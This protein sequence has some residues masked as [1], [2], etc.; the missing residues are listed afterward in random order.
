ML[1]IMKILFVC[2]YKFVYR[3][4]A[5]PFVK[6]LIEGMKAKGCSVDCDLHKFWTNFEDYDIIYLQW[7]E[8]LCLWDKNKIQL[9]KL[10]KHFDILKKKKKK[11][12][13]TC[14]NLHPHNNDELTTELYNL[15]YSKVD[16]IHHLGTYSYNVLKE[17]Y[18]DTFHFI[19]P[20]HVAD[21]MWNRKNHISDIRKILNIPEKDI[22]ISSFGAF[23]NQDEVNLFLNMAKDVGRKGITYLAPRIPIGRLYNGRL[24]NKSLGYITKYIKYKYLNVRY[25]GF[26][27]DEELDEWLCASDIVF[28]QRKEILN[29][30]NVALAFS[31]KKVVVGP[32]MGNVGEILKETHNYTFN[33]DNREMA[34]QETKKAVDACRKGSNL[35]NNNYE[36]AKKNWNTSKVCH[37]IISTLSVFLVCNR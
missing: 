10:S 37:D 36:Y 17:K 16:A 22:V 27:S 14:H 2:T 1:E 3:E 35:G 29:S 32:E 13:I 5:N 4:N 20:H 24:I 12:V 23:R 34:C 26:L 30:G 18:P 15:V 25:A 28:I 9:E 19:V 7:P 8:E 31:A 33:P 11:T 21:E 6:S